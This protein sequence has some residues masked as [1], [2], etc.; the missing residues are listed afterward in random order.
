MRPVTDPELLATLEADEMPQQPRL[1]AVREPSVVA[2]LEYGLDLSKPDDEIRAA[3]A[4]L[5]ETEKKRAHDLWAEHRV[6]KLYQGTGLT[7]QP[8]L[9]K[10]IPIVGPFLDE[11][12][13]G[14]VGLVHNITG[15]GRPYDEALAFARAH[16]RA[17][18]AANPVSSAIGK[19]AAG[20]IA[21]GP[22]AS[23]IAAAPTLAGRVGQGAVLGGTVGAVEGFGHGE[24]SLGD[25]ADTA[26]TGATIGG[27]LG[28]VFPA[29]AAGASRLY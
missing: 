27:S 5:P 29:G 19:L 28:A 22:I 21:G 11:A 20:V 23:R 4:K 25:R 18:E 3:I 15:F 9:A 6:Q 10:G 13:A 16:E 1:R 24:G 7:P 17:A 14:I 8:E 26:M 2:Q 12:T